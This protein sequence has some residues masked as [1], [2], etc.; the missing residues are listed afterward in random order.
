MHE[1]NPPDTTSRPKRLKQLRYWIGYSLFVILLIYSIRQAPPEVWQLQPAWL[2]ATLLFI[3]LMLPLELGQLF[4][5]LSHH[6]VRWQQDILLPIRITTKKSV[7]NATLPAQSGTFLLIYMITNNYNLKW[8]EYVRFMLLVSGFMIFISGVATV[9]LFL[10]PAPYVI[11]L[12]LLL[13]LGT[14]IGR[15]WSQSYLRHTPLLLLSTAGL[16]ILRLFIFWT[17]L[18]ALNYSVRL[19]QASYFAIVTNTL[20]QIPMTPGN[21]GIREALFGFLSPYLSIPTSVGVLIGAIFQLFRVLLYTIF[22]LI[23]DVFYNRRERMKLDETVAP[24]ADEGIPF[25]GLTEEKRHEG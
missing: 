9:G 8:H 11:L 20:A 22:M 16:Y 12:C 3:A 25:R 4:I 14:V 15:I 7:L 19:T 10:P 13:G 1:K 18:H 2:A 17:I 21:I 6:Q 5:F 24:A 23:A